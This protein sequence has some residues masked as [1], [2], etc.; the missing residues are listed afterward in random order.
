MWKLL[1]L[2]QKRP[3]DMTIRILRVAYGI[4]IGYILWLGWADTD[5]WV[6]G[7]VAFIEPWLQGALFAL[8]LIPIVSGATDLGLWK[9]QTARKVQ[10]ATGVFLWVCPLL[11]VPSSQGLLV[12]SSTT[13]Y[14]QIL[15][16]ISVPSTSGALTTSSASIAQI[17]GTPDALVPS[18]PSV[19]YADS[20]LPWFG[21]FP[22]LA[23]ISGKMITQKRWKHGQPISRIRV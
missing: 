7:S 19:F 12:S 2:L 22:I 16:T 18:V 3:S 15:N 21:I 23:G 11:L 10:G 5:V 17:L 20:Y 9:R 4:V 8:A 1:A 13:A 14:T 6:P